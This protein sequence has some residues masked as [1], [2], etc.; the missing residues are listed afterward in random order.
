MKKECMRCHAVADYLIHGC[1][2]GVEGEVCEKCNEELL[3]EEALA[4]KRY[5]DEAYEQHLR[6]VNYREG[7]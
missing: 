3:Q 6:E 1:W 7:E 2:L 5:E 4:Y